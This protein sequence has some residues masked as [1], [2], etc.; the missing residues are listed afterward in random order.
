MEYYLT[1]IKIYVYGWG[2]LYTGKQIMNISL[3][4]IL[5]TQFRDSLAHT[6]EIIYTHPAP[7][8]QPH[9][10]TINFLKIPTFLS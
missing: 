3:L 4:F 7:H 10:D 5:E 2:V 1:H 9:T 6:H 8:P